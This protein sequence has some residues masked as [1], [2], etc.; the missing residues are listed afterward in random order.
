MNL[1]DGVKEF[2]K[3]FSSKTGN[4]WD[5]IKNNFDSF[6]KKNKKFNLVK[7][8]TDQPD[9]LNITQFFNKEM[10]NIKFSHIK[11]NIENEKIR[12]LFNYLIVNAFNSRFG[13][14][15]RHYYSRRNYYNNENEEQSDFSM[16]YFKEE[17]L[18]KAFQIL[19]EIGDNINKI[20]KLKDNKKN[21]K[22][23]EK[24][25]SNEK[26]DLNKIL[27]EL[28]ECN[29]KIL[30]L[31]NEYYELIP[32]TK[33]I[34]EF[35]SPINNMNLLK[36]EIDKCKSYSYIEKTLK[37]FLGSLNYID[38]INPIDYIYE[39]LGIKIINL[40]I[41]ET[42]EKI[43]EAKY[44]I[45]YIK[46]TYNLKKN[47]ITNIFK[48]EN[49]INDIKFN[50]ENKKNRVLLFHGTKIQNILGILSQGLLISPIEASSSGSLYGNGIYLSDSFKKSIDYSDNYNKN[51]V[52]IVECALGNYLQLS[53]KKKFVSVDDLK[54][55]GYDSIISDAQIQMNFDNIIYLKNGCGIFTQLKDTEKKKNNYFQQKYAEY[56]VYNENLVKVKYLVEIS[57][58]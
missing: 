28:K 57:N 33:P 46:M 27:E 52:L 47:R 23:S 9:I 50:P 12:D 53:E 54:N 2:K 14:K 10:K 4:D 38:K 30:H 55:K 34:N 48:I 20:T 3:V 51:Y 11:S 26:S 24:E 36:E 41:E 49:S 56:V 17:S 21:L 32:F 16:M 45:D 43:S 8:T 29:K 25:L 44:L 5:K 6:E 7:L 31:S 39:S 40:N 22:I 37:L 58:C 15:N 13:N 1:E 42:K 35:I 18:N 19:N